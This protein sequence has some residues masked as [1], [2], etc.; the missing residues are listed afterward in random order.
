MR[1]FRKIVLIFVESPIKVIKKIQAKKNIY[2]IVL[3]VESQKLENLRKKYGLNA[4]LKGHEFH[5]SIAKKII[6]K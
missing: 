4:K 3:E 1:Y 2:Y 5:I 6:K